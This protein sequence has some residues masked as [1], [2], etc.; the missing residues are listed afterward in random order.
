MD[1]LCNHF[2]SVFGESESENY[3][4]ESNFNQLNFDKDL[5]ENFSENEL[6]ERQIWKYTETAMDLSVL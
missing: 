4:D 3:F 2:K 5:D 1:D 6:R